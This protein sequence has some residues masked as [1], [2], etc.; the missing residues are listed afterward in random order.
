[1]GL[2]SPDALAYSADVRDYSATCGAIANAADRLG[3]L[4]VVISGAAGHFLAP[5]LGMS[6][7][8]FKAVVDIDLNGTFNVFCACPEF[9]HVAGASLIAIT[10]GQGQAK[11]SDLTQRRT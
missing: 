6:S 2:T 4:D 1:M 8:A 9:L 3:A 10:V 11:S 7:N 5:S